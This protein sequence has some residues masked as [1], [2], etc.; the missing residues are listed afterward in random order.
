MMH[1]Q[2]NIKLMYLYIQAETFLKESEY[3][4]GCSDY[5]TGLD[6]HGFVFPFPANEKYSPCP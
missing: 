3:V 5:V 1:G 6:A 4:T 2:K